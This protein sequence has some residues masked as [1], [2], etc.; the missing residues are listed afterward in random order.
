M[1]DHTQLGPD[2]LADIADRLASEGKQLDAVPFRQMEQTWR[3]ERAE[4]QQAY[5]ESTDLQHR[6]N[7]AMQLGRELATVGAPP[8]VLPLDG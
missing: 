5:N 1:S 7:K 2:Y 4:L 6:L 8:A 3:A